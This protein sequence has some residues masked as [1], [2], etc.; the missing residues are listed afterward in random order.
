M[1]CLSIIFL[2]QVVH[3]TMKILKDNEKMI[4][5]LKNVTVD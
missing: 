4:M 2:E 1:L 3:Q 5:F